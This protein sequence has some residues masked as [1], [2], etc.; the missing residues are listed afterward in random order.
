MLS[1][2]LSFSLQT[3]PIPTSIIEDVKSIL[4]TGDF[5]PDGYNFTS[6]QFSV[7]AF[8]PNCK[9]IDILYKYGMFMI[10]MYLHRYE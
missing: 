1:F 8:Q 2:T 10:M 5:L 9:Y 3:S 4:Q 6:E 7:L